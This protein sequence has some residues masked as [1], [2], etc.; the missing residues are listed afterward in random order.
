MPVKQPIDRR[1]VD[2]L[3]TFTKDNLGSEV[4]GALISPKVCD[5]QFDHLMVHAV[6]HRRA[7]E[8]TTLTAEERLQFDELK[9]KGFFN[10]GTK[11]EL[12]KRPFKILLGLRSNLP[13]KERHNFFEAEGIGAKLY[14]AVASNHKL[15][16]HQD[17]ESAGRGMISDYLRRI[18]S[19]TAFMPENKRVGF[20]SDDVPE[21]LKSHQTFGE[22]LEKT[23]PYVDKYVRPKN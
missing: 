8:E 11:Y 3:F 7:E 22:F 14:E 15:S 21:I 9:S 20:L 16:H 18:S 13:S 4:R 12:Y 2:E 10:K 5:P 6:A 17:V 19:I 1:N 23:L